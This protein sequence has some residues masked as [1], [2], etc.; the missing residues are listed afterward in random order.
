MV[1]GNPS[2]MVVINEAALVPGIAEVLEGKITEQLKESRT[3]ASLQEYLHECEV[4]LT[5]YHL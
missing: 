1:Q 2:V 3:A 4:M 5:W